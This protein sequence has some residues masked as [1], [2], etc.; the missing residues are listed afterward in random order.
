MNFSGCE[1]RDVEDGDT[2]L[3]SEVEV[4]DILWVVVLINIV[5]ANL[6]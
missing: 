2:G 4:E 5:L 1:K 3:Y 6:W